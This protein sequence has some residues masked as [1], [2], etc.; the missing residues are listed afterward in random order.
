MRCWPLWQDMDQEPADELVRFEGHGFVPTG[1]T[2]TVILD[3]EG[4]AV[5]V[6]S[7]QSAVGDGD[8]VRV[9]RQ[10]CQH[11][12]GSGEGFLGVD[13]PVDFAQRVEKRLEG[14]PV[15]QVSMIAVELQFPRIVQPD[16]PVQNE[17]PIQTGQH[18]DGQEEVLAAGDPFCAIR[19]KP[20]TR[21]DHMDM[22]VMGHGRTPSVQHRGNADTA[23]QMFW[24]RRDPDHRVRART[25]QQI[26]DLAFVLTR[27]I[28]DRFGQGEDQV[29]IP[30]RQQLGLAR[31]QPCLRGPGLTFGTVTIA[32]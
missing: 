32:A 29:E 25:H 1:A 9:A 30:H 4:D 21:H 15:Q 10:I 13:H 31:R 23:P 6:H 26:I 14:I 7:D 24:V 11:G 8:P 12:F 18:P 16:H 5:V 17:T 20:S 28:S 19:R 2:D 3:A 22:R 27:D